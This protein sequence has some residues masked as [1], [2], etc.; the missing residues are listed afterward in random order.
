[1][2]VLQLIDTLQTGGAER[3]A[4][5]YANG[6]VRLGVDSHICATRA[7]GL[8]LNTIDDSVGY[9]FLNRSKTIDFRAIFKLRSYLILNKIEIIHAHASSYF[10]ATLVKVTLPRIKIVWHDHYGNSE[11]LSQRPKRVLSLCSLGFSYVFCVNQKL[12]AWNKEHLFVKKIKYIKNFPVLQKSQKNLT[13]LKGEGGKRLLCLANLRDQKNHSMLLD[14]FKIV[15][16]EFPDWSLHCVGKDFDDKCSRQFFSKIKA[17]KLN[18][19][20]HF[21]DSKTDILNIMSQ[22]EIGL[23]SSKS[24]GLPLALLEYGMSGLPVVVTDVGNCRLLVSDKSF[25]QLVDKNDYM[26][27]AESIKQLILDK[28]YRLFCADNLNQK[29]TREY[30]EKNVLSDIISIYKS[31]I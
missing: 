26:Q 16:N 25:G 13:V 6:L 7:E 21:Y 8:L 23:L 2:K 24:E 3:L 17:L 11:L 28:D 22:C 29:V 30:S 14:A 19:S 20:V 31:I 18:K 15:N 27:F 10:F 5:N 4:V 1:M 9:L 12:K